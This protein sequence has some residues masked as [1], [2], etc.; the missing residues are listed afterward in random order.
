M[1]VFRQD[2]IPP[3]WCELRGFT[4]TD[5]ARGETVGGE[6]RTAKERLLVTRGA[7]Q[8]S[9][10]GGSQVLREGQFL[11]LPSEASAWTVLAARD[12]Q[13]VRL[14]GR[15]GDEVGGCGVFRGDEP[16]EPERYRRS[17][18]LTRRRPASTRT[19]TTATSTG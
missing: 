17:R 10:A 16:R 11:D 14:S 15:W 3:G 1:P 13:V 9:F 18:S 12:A 5:L 6:R 2:D 7:V 19:I 4:V 8:V